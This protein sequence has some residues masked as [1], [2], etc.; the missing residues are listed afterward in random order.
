MS[1]IAI[2]LSAIGQ[3][4][5]QRTFQVHSNQLLF[6]LLL[7]VQGLLAISNMHSYILKSWLFDATVCKVEF[8]TS[9]SYDI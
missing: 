4:M 3:L 2:M 8:N 7:P 9:L 5:F 6:L 1:G